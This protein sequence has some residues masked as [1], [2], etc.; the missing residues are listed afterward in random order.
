M[1]TAQLPGMGPFVIRYPRGRGEHQDWKCPLEAIEVG[2]GRRLK[3]GQDIALLSLGPIG[4]TAAEAI[5]DFEQQQAEEG[6]PLTVAHY[7]MRFLKPLDEDILHEAG[8]RFSRIITLEDGVVR[9]GLGSA[10]LEYMADHGFC[11]RVARMGLP[12]QF[13]EHGTVEQLKH[14]V[15]IDRE[16][17]IAQLRAISQ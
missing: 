2:R 11:P 9:G 8:T 14:I 5:R 15:G 4:N 3:D 17:I 6:R 12:D 10:V 13:V 16:A 1:Y 7:D